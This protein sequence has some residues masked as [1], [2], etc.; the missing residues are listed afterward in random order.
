MV[1]FLLFL[2]GCHCV[3]CEQL[4]CIYFLVSIHSSAL[5]TD[6]CLW[7]CHF[8]FMQFIKWKVSFAL[9]SSMW[10][11][12]LYYA[13]VRKNFISLPDIP[14]AVRAL[15]L[16]R[17]CDRIICGRIFSRF[18]LRHFFSSLFRICNFCINRRQFHPHFSLFSSHMYHFLL[19]S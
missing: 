16:V 10:Q 3:F 8:L 12:K 11:K 5:I 17:L 7:T 15:R 1:S 13:T 6:S 14:Y 9:L 2:S 4:V 19:L 18:L